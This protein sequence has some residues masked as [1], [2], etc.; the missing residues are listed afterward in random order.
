MLQTDLTAEYMYGN[1]ISISIKETVNIKNWENKKV[2]KFVN[3]LRTLAEA[4]IREKV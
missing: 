1:A 4:D 2:N 3:L